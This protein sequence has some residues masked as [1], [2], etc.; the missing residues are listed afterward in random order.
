MIARFGFLLACCMAAIAPAMLIISYNA[1][2]RAVVLA[3]G[4]YAIVLFLLIVFDRRLQAIVLEVGQ[5]QRS[6]R[7]GS[8]PWFDVH[9]GV[10]GSRLGGLPLAIL[11]IILFFEFW[12][13]ILLRGISSEAAVAGMLGF[14]IS[15]LLTLRAIGDSAS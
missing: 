2:F 4:V 6:P 10:F 3:T 9:W 12:V 15:I 8:H 7:A 1:L 11:R 14:V 5:T 13:A